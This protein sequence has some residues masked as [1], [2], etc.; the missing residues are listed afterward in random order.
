MISFRREQLFLVTGASSGIGR[1]VTL[2]LTE[3]GASV[4]ALGRD[5]RKLEGVRLD[6]VRPETVHLCPYDLMQ[7]P[8]CLPQ[9]VEDIRAQY[10][11]LAGFCSCA[12]TMYMDGLRN[13]EYSQSVCVFTMHTLVPLALARAV[14]DACNC[15]GP[16][17]SIVFIAAAGGVV[18]Q[19]GLLSYGAAKAALIAAA[20]NMS[21][22]MGS[23]HIRVNCVSPALVRTPMTE[24]DYAGLM[25]YDVLAQEA[26]N[27]PLGLGNPEDVAAAVVFLLSDR[28]RWISGRNLLLDGGRY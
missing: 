27:Y 19:G 7:D 9:L 26:G 8:G 4:V 12:G 10:G 28:A 23:R 13:Y 6:S 21:K 15:V 2:L 16:G 5:K 17:T 18:P 14:T 11:K 20:K 3:L 25:G 24:G 1:A 22:E